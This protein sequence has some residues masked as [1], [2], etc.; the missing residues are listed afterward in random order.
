MLEGTLK[1][2][3]INPKHKIIQKL[4]ADIPQ[5]EGNAAL[6]ANVD[7]TIHMLFAQACIIEGEPLKDTKGFAKRINA[8][9]TQSLAA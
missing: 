7:D 9:L 1:I 8:L 6:K 2:F 3:E 5:I 4:A